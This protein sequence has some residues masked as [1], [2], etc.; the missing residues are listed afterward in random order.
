M[1]FQLTIV[2]IRFLLCMV[3][4]TKSLASVGLAQ[5]RPNYSSSNAFQSGFW[6]M[7]IVR[8]VFEVRKISEAI[9]F[10]IMVDALEHLLG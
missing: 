7:L 2:F 4:P 1:V 10:G 9:Q 5:A 8:H 6:A 3:H